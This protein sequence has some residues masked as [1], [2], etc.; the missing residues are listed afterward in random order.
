M[1]PARV[2]D[3]RPGHAVRIA[4]FGA[5]PVAGTPAHVPP[6]LVAVRLGWDGL[7]L[8]LHPTTPL[9]AITT[10]PAVAYRPMTCRLCAG[11]G[12]WRPGRKASNG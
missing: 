8:V 10:A 2:A 9:D 12:L 1:T 5:I 4:G 6:P 11:T 7:S 3:L